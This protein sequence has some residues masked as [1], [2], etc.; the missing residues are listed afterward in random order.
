MVQKDESKFNFNVK[1]HKGNPVEP[2][3]VFGLVEISFLPARR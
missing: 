1:S 2:T 3:W